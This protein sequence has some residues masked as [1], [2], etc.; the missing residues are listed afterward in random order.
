MAQHGYHSAEVWSE[1]IL[2]RL[3]PFHAARIREEL[4]EHEFVFL[5]GDISV[6]LPGEGDGN[7]ETARA[8]STTP[9][10]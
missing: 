10:M 9:L 3:F 5:N 2:T 6:K 7:G 4:D 8:A 1:L